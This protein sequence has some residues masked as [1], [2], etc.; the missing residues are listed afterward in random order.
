[1]N[2]APSIRRGLPVARISLICIRTASTAAQK[3]PPGAERPDHGEKI[4]VFSHM[5]SNQIIYSLKPVLDVRSLC[6]PD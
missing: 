1:M 2:I 3:G 6:R 4:W 5:L